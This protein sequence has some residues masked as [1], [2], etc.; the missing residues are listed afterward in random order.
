MIRNT[1]M[2]MLI[3]DRLKFDL[4]RKSAPGIK[5]CVRPFMSVMLLPKADTG[6]DCHEKWNV[7]NRCPP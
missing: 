3:N 6:P 2:S 1:S 5:E 4:A 7:K